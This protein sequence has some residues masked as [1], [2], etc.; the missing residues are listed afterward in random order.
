M[1]IGAFAQQYMENR[2]YAQKGYTRTEY[3]NRIEYDAYTGTY[4]RV[5]YCRTL[6]WYQNYYS[7]QVYYMDAA[8]RWYTRWQ[9]GYFWY[10][11][12]SGWYIC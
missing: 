5:R 4:Y 7:G 8:G 6:T 11:V 1:F 3:A 12:W 9:N 10:C 2:Y